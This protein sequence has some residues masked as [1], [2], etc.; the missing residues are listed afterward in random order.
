MVH[1]E[2]FMLDDIA[3]YYF[4]INIMILLKDLQELTRSF[5]FH[6]ASVFSLKHC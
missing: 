6:P 3:T 2:S 1:N 5:F 4:Y